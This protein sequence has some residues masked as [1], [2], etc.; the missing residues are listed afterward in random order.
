M[1][2]IFDSDTQTLKAF[3]PD[4]HCRFQAECHD[5]AV[6]GPGFGRWGRCPRGEFPLGA[7]QAHD[8]PAFGL[9][10]TPIENTPGRQGIGIHGGGSR[11]LN[12]FAPRQGWAST[13]GCLRLQNEDNTVLVAHLKSAILRHEKNKIT[14]QGK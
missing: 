1:H 6:L 13:H 8:E 4:G 9:W 11:L 14:V 10:F 5:K 7:P 12:P 3:D 2:L